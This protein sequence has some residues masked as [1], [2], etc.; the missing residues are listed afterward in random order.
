MS[1]SHPRRPWLLSAFFLIALLL[2]FPFGHGHAAA[3]EVLV[4][5]DAANTEAKAESGQL[6][7]SKDAKGIEVK[8]K[9]GPDGYPGLS[10]TR[11]EG[12]PFDLSAHGHIKA[13]F[14]NTGSTP[15]DVALRADNAGDWKDEP[16]NTENLNIAPGGQA[17]LHLIFGHSFGRKKS[18]ALNPKEVTRLLV[19]TGKTGAEKSFRI[20][21]IIAGGEPGEQPQAEPEKVRVRPKNG[22]VFPPVDDSKLPLFEGINGATG[23]P[24][25]NK[26]LRARFHEPGSQVL[27]RP[28]EGRWDLSQSVQVV[29]TLNNTGEKPVSPTLRLDSD[30]GP[31]DTVQAG[32]LAPGASREIAISFIPQKPWQGR[33]DY[34]GKGATA[35][36]GT[37]TRFTSDAVSALAISAGAADARLAVT[38]IMANVPPPKSP[39]WLGKR[40]PVEGEWVQTFSEEFEGATVDAGKWNVHAANYWDKSSWFSRDNVILGNGLARL[41]YEKR[42]GRHNDDPAGKEFHYATGLLDTYDK[43]TQRY[44][45]YEVRVKLPTAPGLWPAFWLMPERGKDA[46]EQWQRQNTGDGGMEFDVVE[47]LT[48]WGPYRNNVAMHWDGYGEEHKH[49]G[50]DRIYMQPDAQGF[51]TAGLLWLPGQAIYYVNGS[52][53]GRWESPRISS[54]PS[55]LLF[56][57]PQGGWDNSPIDDSKLP[58]DFAIDY[59]RIW[60]RKDLAGSVQGSK[61][62]E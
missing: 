24:G 8:I 36:D 49:L 20:D 12:K 50:S 18:F 43:W 45:Y 15:L 2:L 32:E 30:G 23:E 21:S 31:S 11:P 13:T 6:S 52:E 4:G 58:D 33:P 35:I 40:P 57:L 42:T 48:R 27:I 41:R 14:T 37:G 19:F 16:Y 47:H 26:N 29:V 61:L 3:P 39:A 55:C 17:T 7:F 28:A 10:I 25:S 51:I 1:P 59:V 62:D 38:A 54:V 44:G 60:Q 9:P 34:D 22:S 5:A 46:G 53:T 56:T